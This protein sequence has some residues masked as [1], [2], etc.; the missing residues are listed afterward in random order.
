MRNLDAALR[1]ISAIPLECASSFPKKR[2]VSP[3]FSP[4]VPNHSICT[5]SLQGC[6]TYSSPFLWRPVSI[7]CRHIAIGL[8]RGFHGPQVLW[9]V[10]CSFCN[11]IFFAVGLL[12]LHPTSNLEDQCCF[13]S[14]HYPLTCP[15]WLNLPGALRPRQYSSPSP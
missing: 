2:M 8:A 11:S 13:L 7:C 4:C 14:G 9:F 6:P 3:L 1:K 12:A 10:F 15:A 5:H